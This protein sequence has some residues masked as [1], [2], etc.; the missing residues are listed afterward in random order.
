[1]ITGTVTDDGSPIVRLPVAGRDWPA[2]VDS[3][4]NGDLELPEAFGR[5]VNAR[6]LGPQRASLASGQ[7]VVE[8]LFNVDFP[9]DGRT[10]LAEASFVPGD[11]ILLG[12]R[13]LRQ[14]RLVIDFPAR[15]VTLERTA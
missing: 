11:T 13:L 15:T 8:E 1:V 12:T 5:H 3:G 4:F 10:V 7:E 2:V 9:F 14:Y 6:Y